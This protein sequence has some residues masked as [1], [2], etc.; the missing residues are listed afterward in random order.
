MARL[1]AGTYVITYVMPG[2]EQ[3]LKQKT[4]APTP[5]WL[6]D[7]RPKGAELAV[8]FMPSTGLWRVYDLRRFAIIPGQVGRSRDGLASYPKPAAEV[9]DIDAAIAAAVLLSSAP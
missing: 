1:S 8:R 5:Q 6:W 2:G 9:A 7:H 4:G 3:K